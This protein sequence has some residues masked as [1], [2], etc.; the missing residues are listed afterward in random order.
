MKN[1]WIALGVVAVLAT[2]ELA[3]AQGLI[4]GA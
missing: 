2:P 3:S 4:G 1:R